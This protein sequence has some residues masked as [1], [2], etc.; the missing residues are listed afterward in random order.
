MNP[1]RSEKG[2]IT[3]VSEGGTTRRSGA[4]QA[5]VTQF[6]AAL[7]AAGSPTATGPARSAA[8]LQL[9]AAPSA[10]RV[11]HAGELSVHERALGLR[12]YRQEMLASNIANADTPGYKAVDF[13]VSAALR[14]NYSG[15][16][17]PPLQYRVPIQASADNNTVDLDIE[18]VQ[19]AQNALMYEFAV[20]RVRGHYKEMEELL[21]GTPF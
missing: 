12:A 10:A 15:S 8:A 11:S 19:F 16:N 14:D 9:S 6:A 21:K 13:D 17:K 5:G 3:F 4:S 2:A 7:A 20:D 1:I 18:R